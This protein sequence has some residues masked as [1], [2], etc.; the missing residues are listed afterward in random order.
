MRAERR[1]AE[2]GR[3]GGVKQSVCRGPFVVFG[4]TPY[5]AFLV[6]SGGK[7]GGGATERDGTRRGK[8]LVLLIETARTDKLAVVKR[9]GIWRVIL[10]CKW[11]FVWCSFLALLPGDRQLWFAGSAVEDATQSGIVR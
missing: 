6:G 10:V 7:R 3:T 8:W 4:E 2:R 9:M 11:L 1:Q 5:D